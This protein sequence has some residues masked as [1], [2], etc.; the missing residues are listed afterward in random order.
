M[1]PENAVRDVV[2]AGGGI[3]GWSAAAALR[4]HLPDIAVTVVAAP[5]PADALADRIG[6]TLPS[7]IAFHGDL[8]LSEANAV[9]RTGSG[10]RLGTL[11][12]DWAEG[13]PAYLHTY[14]DHGRPFGPT[15][16]HLHWLRVA[17]EADA[18]AFDAFSP[19]AEIARGGRFV[20]PQGEPGSVLASFEYALQLNPAG[21]QDLMRAFAL[22]LGATERRVG[23][24]GVE[25]RGGDGFVAALRLDDGSS[26]SA[27]LFLDCTGPAARIRSALDER[28][29]DWSHYLPCDRLLFGAAPAPADIPPID[30]A[31]ATAS[32]WCWQSAAPAG[33]SHGLV[34]AS[35]H[36]ADAEAERMLRTESDVEASGPA[37]TIR[38]GRR[39]APWLRNCVA[40]GD[41]A[42]SVEPLEWTNLHLAHSAIDRIVAMMPGRDCAPIELTEFNRQS[43]VEADRIRDFLMLHYVTARRPEPFWRDAAAMPLSDGLQHTLSLFRERGR[44]PF[45]EEET[46]ARTSWLDILL[47]VGEMPRRIDPLTRAVPLAH[48]QAAMTQ[49]RDSIRAVAANLP[50]HTNYLRNMMRQAAR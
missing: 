5:P 20:H 40:V 1:M 45:H 11:F 6:S 12:E 48:A 50:T 49:M 44:L 23:I 35:A 47:G 43:M 16:F 13:R 10:Y 34:Y 22:H 25:L 2:V 7:I 8:G 26:L 24:A 38:Q 18:A 31:K 32:G 36:L 21:Y 4:R 27:D 9:A 41:A 37:L 14:G 3:V 28:F 19:A 42:V 30:R 39:P 29:E 46:F 33:S 15:S 17:A